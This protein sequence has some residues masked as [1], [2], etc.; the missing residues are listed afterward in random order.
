MA[1]GDREK[2]KHV[3][4]I[5]NQPTKTRPSSRAA[6]GVKRAETHPTWLI[7]C[8]RAADSQRGSP[9]WV[10]SPPPGGGLTAG[11]RRRWWIA[12]RWQ[13]Y[14][15]AVGRRRSLIDWHRGRAALRT[16]EPPAR[17]SFKRTRRRRRLRR[18][19]RKGRVSRTARH[20]P[21][22]VSLPRTSVRAELSTW[23]I[24]SLRPRHAVSWHR[25]R[26]PTSL[27]HQLAQQRDRRRRVLSDG[28][29]T[30]HSR[31]V[32]KKMTRRHLSV[33]RNINRCT[34]CHCWTVNQRKG[35]TNVE[36]S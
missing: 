5:I 23:Q 12:A 7:H 6:V 22:L 2:R 33:R 27:Q 19:D 18:D 3:R 1:A 4:R 29:F 28:N 17:P 31:Y 20:W 21:A 10:V 16:L 24:N 8:V 30:N 15:L 13:R 32:L 26:G 9:G 14:S 34:H 25:D 35:K 11:R 36:T